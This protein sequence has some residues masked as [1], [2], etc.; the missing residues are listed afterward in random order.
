MIFDVFNPMLHKTSFNF[1][2]P[3]KQKAKVKVKIKV[4]PNET[5]RSGINKE[6]KYLY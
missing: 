1:V 6:K 4:K 2:Y 5:N 3:R